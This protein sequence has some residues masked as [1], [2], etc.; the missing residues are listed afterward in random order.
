[1]LCEMGHSCHTTHETTVSHSSNSNPLKTHR[2]QNA[3]KLNAWELLCLQT[4]LEK[5]LTTIEPATAYADS[6]TALL[7]KIASTAIKPVKKA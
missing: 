6:V 2:K 1:M 5:H 3:M 7:D 4:V